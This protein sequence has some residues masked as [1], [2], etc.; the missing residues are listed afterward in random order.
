MVHRNL[1]VHETFRQLARYGVVGLSTNA[2]GY[3]IYLVL[4]YFGATPKLT[5][6][7][8]YAVGATAGF[9]GNRTLTFSHKGR[10]LNSGL[11]Y[12]VAHL[13]G[14]SINLMLLSIFSDW[15]GYKHQ[16][17]QAAAVFIVAAFLFVVLKY[18]VFSNPCNCSE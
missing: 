5:M 8:L 2:L 12:I 7:L 1:F 10:L 18:F 4:T 16:L 3:C 9:V 17:V 11:R 15:L 13:A 14:F 6:T